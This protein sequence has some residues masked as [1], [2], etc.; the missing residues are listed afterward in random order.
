MKETT[1]ICLL[2]H[3]S[4]NF[5]ILNWFQELPLWVLWYNGIASIAI[6][7]QVFVSINFIPKK[8]NHFMG[9]KE[10]EILKKARDFEMRSVCFQ[11]ALRTNETLIKILE[12][13]KMKY[14]KNKNTVKF[15]K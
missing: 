1:L 6:S 3:F 11:N 13:K 5:L 8:L 4:F 2:G 9:K 14:M 15:I 12:N 10:R 7:I